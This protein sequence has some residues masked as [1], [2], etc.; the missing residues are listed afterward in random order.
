MVINVNSNNDRV[1]SEEEINKYLESVIDSKEKMN[2]FKLTKII[3]V[4]CKLIFN[5]RLDIEYI[6]EKLLPLI[7]NLD[8]TLNED[9]DPIEID[10]TD[11]IKKFKEV[12]L[13]PDLGGFYT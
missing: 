12:K 6:K 8:K 13:E 10:G 7:E 2:I 4:L 11:G 3:K 1:I 9:I 5:I